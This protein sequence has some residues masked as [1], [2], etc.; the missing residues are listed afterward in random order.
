MYRITFIN[1]I[2]IWDKETDELTK[3]NYIIADKIEWSKKK[4]FLRAG[5]LIV[6]VSNIAGI[7]HISKNNKEADV[8]VVKKKGV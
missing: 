6:P 7:H 5:T 1:R 8:N 3:I 2:I 4:K